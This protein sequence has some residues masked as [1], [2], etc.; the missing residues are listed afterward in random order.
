MKK[1]LSLMLTAVM[2]M[3]MGICVFAEDTTLA[4]A[5]ENFTTFAD[6]NL[7]FNST[8][9][10]VDGS[11]ATE[12]GKLGKAASDTSAVFNVSNYNNGGNGRWAYE[13]K[14]N[15]HKQN[16]LEPLYL[17]MGS[18]YTGYLVMDFNVM[19]AGNGT[20]EFIQI[21]TGTQQ[22]IA[23]IYENNANYKANQWN[24]IRMIYDPTG[25]GMFL[26]DPANTDKKAPATGTK[27]GTFKTYLNGQLIKTSEVKTSASYSYSGVNDAGYIYL[28]AGNTPASTTYFD[29]LKIYISETAEAP[30]MPKL[31]VGEGYTVDNRKIHIANAMPV[32]NLQQSF[33][34]GVVRAY[35]DATFSTECA[36]VE[37]GNVVVLESTDKLYSYYEVEAV[38]WEDVTLTNNWTQAKPHEKLELH[39]ITGAE[40]KG[41]FG[42]D[43]DDASGYYYSETSNIWNLQ[44]KHGELVYQKS[45]LDYSGYLVMEFNFMFDD[46]V[47]SDYYLQISCSDVQVQTS[48]EIKKDNNYYK[49]NQWNHLKFVYDPAGHGEFSASEISEGA[50]IGSGTTYL[51]GVMI[52]DNEKIIATDGMAAQKALPTKFYIQGVLSM[53]QGMF[54]DDLKIYHSDSK[55]APV[56][57]EVMKSDKYSIADSTVYV[58]NDANLKAADIVTNTGNYA[59]SAYADDSFAT[60]LGVDAVLGENNVIVITDGTCYSY[61]AVSVFDAAVSGTTV[62]AS[63]TDARKGNCV[64]I[65]EY[66]GDKLIGVRLET[67]VAN[68]D[69]SANY[70]LTD[71]TNTVRAFVLNSMT[72]IIPLS[73]SIA[74]K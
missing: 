54:I 1:I 15:Y 49:E 21:L 40:Q 47:N 8:R 18:E 44:Y 71:A 33:T 60:K 50:V 22:E 31:A 57:P 41:K 68:G 9:L 73:T 20:T 55:E 35:T 3:S 51:N 2:L 53:N 34:E 23:Y 27:L 4:T 36:T 30:A 32:Q 63:L 69:L 16:Y 29:D 13:Y 65:A 43:A 74:V 11:T 66:E 17:N 58:K 39:R 7:A 72:D 12:T 52:Q 19:F 64:I 45:A 24:N 62:T 25:H 10:G 56:M 67:A 70:T 46:K 48:E 37:A 61:Y 26:N 14:H 5:T 59:V 28:F 42:K 38:V 6:R